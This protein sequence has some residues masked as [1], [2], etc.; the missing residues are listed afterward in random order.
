MLIVLP[1]MAGFVAFQAKVAIL[2]L[3]VGHRS[4]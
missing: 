2:Q 3:M 1:G 4:V